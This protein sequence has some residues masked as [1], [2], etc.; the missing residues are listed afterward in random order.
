MYSQSTMKTAEKVN[1]VILVSLL[2][3][4]NI[5][6]V[7]LLLLLLT[8]NRKMFAGNQIIITETEYLNQSLLKV[9]KDRISQETPSG[10]RP[11][12]MKFCSHSHFK[13]HLSAT[14]G[15]SL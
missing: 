11:V 7:F 9:Q 13:E 4:V 8:L 2:L 1:E 5:F 3:T 12:T 10:H 15:F 14:V 6:I